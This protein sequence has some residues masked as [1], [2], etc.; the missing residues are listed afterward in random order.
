MKTLLT[1]FFNVLLLSTAFAQVV[2]SNTN[3]WLHYVGNFNFS[4]KIGSTLEATYRYNNNANTLQQFFIRPSFDYK[5]Q[6]SL[7]ASL[8]YTYV[9]TGVYGNPAINKIN[10]PENNV[11]IQ[12]NIQN[13]IGKVNLTNR[14][15]NENRIVKLANLEENKYILNDQT[16]RNRMR[17][18]FLASFPLINFENSQALNGLV[19]DEVFLNIG[20][21]AGKTFVNQ[22][23]LIA[24]LGYRLNSSHQIQLAYIFQNVWNTPNTI[25]EDNNTIRLSYLSNLN[26]YKTKQ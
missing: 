6:K 16:Y 19:G 20:K 4:P 7:T 26:F 8:G 21:N 9:L 13:K 22:N 10:M 12:A 23:R 18:M 25:K 14:I 24:G 5:L 17:Y 2:S 3:S 11:W 15:R 1:F